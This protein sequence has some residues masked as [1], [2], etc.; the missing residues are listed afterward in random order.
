MTAIEGPG[1]ERSLPELEAVIERGRQTFVD[2]GLAL[3]EI[4]H[5]RLF[6]EQG[7]ATFTD[8]CRQR[9]QFTPVRAVR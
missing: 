8:Y 6:R 7:F 9:W 3:L 1:Q 5:R 4:R 2:V